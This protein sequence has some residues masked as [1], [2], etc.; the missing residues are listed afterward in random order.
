MV[1]IINP[2]KE[3][4][5]ITVP[6]EMK[7]ICFDVGLAGEAVNSGV[8]LA[9]TT[10]RFVVGVEPLNYHWKMITNFATANTPRPWPDHIPV[11]QL[12]EGVVKY[13]GKNVSSIGERFLGIE[14]AIDNV[15]GIEKKTFYKM[16]K[17]L[18]ASGS[19]SLLKPSSTHPHF[20]EEE[21]TVPVVS[22]EKILDH[23]D[24]ERFPY[25]EHIKTDCE[26]K[27]FDVVQSIGKYLDRVLLITSELSESNKTHWEGV[28]EHSKFREWIRDNG[29]AEHKRG[30]NV[31]FI[32]TNLHSQVGQ[33]NFYYN[34]WNE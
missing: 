9:E 28:K 20:V 25:I 32:N 19:S 3:D 5:K 12:E 34:M 22:L 2:L 26:G 11:V 7:Q 16:D 30:D 23:I 1:N 14:C 17:R 27:D 10:D 15:E 21:L 13:Q 4:I 6:D 33:G 8:W 31:T 24:W 18:G 29:F